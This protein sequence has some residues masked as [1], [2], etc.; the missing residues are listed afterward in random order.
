MA[1]RASTSANP[2][3][4]IVAVALAIAAVAGGYA[5]FGK[6]GEPYRTMTPLPVRDY[7]E[8]ANSL[9]GDVYKLEGVV[10][11]SLEWSAA[12]GRLFSVDVGSSTSGDVLPVV[13][14]PQFNN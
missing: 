14:P 13:I 8:N 10:S 1:R 4:L 2:I 9:R 11:N 5:L 6:A 3:W 7:L 12:R